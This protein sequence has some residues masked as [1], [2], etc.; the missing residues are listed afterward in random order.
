[1]QGLPYDLPIVGY[2]NAVNT[3]RLWSARAVDEFDLADF[4]KGSYVE[5]VEGKVLAENLTKVLYPND[6][7]MAGKELRLRQQYF[8]VACSVKDILRRYRELNDGWDALPD[9]V[10]IHLNETHPA[11]AIPELMRILVGPTKVPR[12]P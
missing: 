8:F 1:M 11:L 3:L 2:R 5:A 9:K 4:N 6:N 12:V 10:F 7:T